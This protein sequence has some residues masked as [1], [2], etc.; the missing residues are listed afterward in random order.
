MHAGLREYTGE[1]TN[2]Y[3]IL[4]GKPRRKIAVWRPRGRSKYNIK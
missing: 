4:V 2:I 3:I 1:T